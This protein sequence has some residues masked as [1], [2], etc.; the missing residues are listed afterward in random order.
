MFYLLDLVDDLNFRGVVLSQSNLIRTK[1]KT[2]SLSDPDQNL[3]VKFN[4]P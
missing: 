1:E 4:L 2:F 3:Y